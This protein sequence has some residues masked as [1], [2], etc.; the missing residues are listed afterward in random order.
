MKKLLEIIG[1]LIILWLLTRT[2][3]HRAEPPR[4][5]AACE[6]RLDKLQ[7]DIRDIDWKVARQEVMAED[8]L[9]KIESK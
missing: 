2:V 4:A 3:M 1:M 6:E 9:K 8:I 7:Q 5:E